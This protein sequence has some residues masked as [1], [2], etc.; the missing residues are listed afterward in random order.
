MLYQRARILV[1]WKFLGTSK[2]TDRSNYCWTIVVEAASEIM[3]LQHRMVDETDVLDSFRPTG[4]IESCFINNGYFLAASIACFILQHRKDV[5]SMQT[6]S[7]VQTLLEKS[8]TIW[9][10]TND[11][12]REAIKVVAALRHVL[13]YPEPPSAQSPRMDVNA[14]PSLPP[15]D[16]AA[17][18]SNTMSF[19]GFTSFFDDLPLLMTDVDTAAVFPSLPSIPVID[20]WPQV[21]RNSM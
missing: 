5:L 9:N 21:N 6:L 15:N 12:S 20:Y 18:S 16:A 19:P 13:G 17:F 1:N 3:R 2:D 10:R 8:L 14:A 7:E 4:M 11:L